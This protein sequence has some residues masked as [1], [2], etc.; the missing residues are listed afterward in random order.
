V[1]T[2]ATPPAS[3]TAPPPRHRLALLGE[4]NNKKPMVKILAA[5][6]AGVE[7]RHGRRTR[8]CNSN[9]PSKSKFK[10][11]RHGY[12]RDQRSLREPGARLPEADE[13]GSQGSRVNPNGGRSRSAPLAPRARASP[14]PWRAS[15]SSRAR[16][17]PRCRCASA[18]ARLA[19]ILER[20]R[21]ERPGLKEESKEQKEK[22]KKQSKTKAEFSWQDPLLST[23]SSRRRS[24]WCATPRTTTA[25]ASWHREFS[26]PL[27]LKKQ[28]K[29]YSGDGSIGLLGR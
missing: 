25:R 23:S 29:K 12:Y 7:P 5:A 13:G 18:S 14:S 16:A 24:A 1:V 8:L 2:R 6:S 19:V 3:T 17:T 22:S 15:C 27:D 11:E 4:R 28:I 10:I 20:V 26:K 21:N 9:S